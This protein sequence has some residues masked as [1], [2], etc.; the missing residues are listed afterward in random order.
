MHIGLLEDAGEG[1]GRVYYLRGT[2]VDTAAPTWD[3]ELVDVV[4]NVRL[5]F[6]QIVL[7]G[8]GIPTISY[9]TPDEGG[10]HG[11]P[12]S[13]DAYRRRRPARLLNISTRARVQTDDN[14]LIGGFIIT[15]TSRRR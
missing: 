13:A 6:M 7:N 12:E 4:G 10:H 2:G 11:E 15:G 5:D 1:R 3:E 9:T 14:V 8:N